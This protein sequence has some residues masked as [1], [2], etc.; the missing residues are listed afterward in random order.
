[1]LGIPR[2]L[3]P[4]RRR[5]R[6]L[7]SGQGETLTGQPTDQGATPHRQSWLARRVSLLPRTPQVGGCPGPV[8]SQFCCVLYSRE[9]G[10]APGATLRVGFGS[11]VSSGVFPAEGQPQHMHGPKL[12]ASLVGAL[13]FDPLDFIGL[14]VAMA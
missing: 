6:R 9:E 10:G 8:A 1:M 14:R 13:Q 4:S 11:K 2:S 12:V 5:E 7:N 3:F